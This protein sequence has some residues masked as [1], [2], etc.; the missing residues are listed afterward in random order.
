M[1]DD[2][3]LMQQG[4][5]PVCRATPARH[6]KRKSQICLNIMRQRHGIKPTVVEVDGKHYEVSARA[7]TNEEIEAAR[8]GET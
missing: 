2:F 4:I 8:E 6:S 5:C 1:T 3:E 7:A